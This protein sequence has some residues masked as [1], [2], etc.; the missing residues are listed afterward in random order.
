MFN[1]TVD[2]LQTT[3]ILTGH[4]VNDTWTVEHFHA[5]PS[6]KK[7]KIYFENLFYGIKEFSEYILFQ[8]YLTHF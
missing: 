3:W 7:M 5:A 6:V 8:I 1:I 4:V 2:D